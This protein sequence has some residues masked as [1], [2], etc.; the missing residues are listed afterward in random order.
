MENLLK[1]ACTHELRELLTVWHALEVN[2]NATQR[3]FTRI[4]EKINKVCAW[5]DQI[6]KNEN[7]RA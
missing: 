7:F 3:D 6:E 5:L 2:P 4:R 1:D